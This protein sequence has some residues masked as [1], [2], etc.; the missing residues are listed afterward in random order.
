MEACEV[1]KTGLVADGTVTD[2]RR[3]L[4][5]SSMNDVDLLSPPQILYGLPLPPNKIADLSALW[6]EITQ[7]GAIIRILID[8][9]D[10]IKFLEV[11]ESR[12]ETPRTWSVFV[13]VD[14]GG[15]YVRIPMLH[16]YTLTRR[17]LDEQDW[18]RHHQP[19]KNS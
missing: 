1:V 5:V 11:F 13:K 19:L 4:D 12:R 7:H 2:V 6:D 15:K 17:N 18:Y 16:Y 14:A 3:V 8:H 9:P 10:Q